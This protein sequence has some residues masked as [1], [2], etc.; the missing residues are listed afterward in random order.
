MRK[1]ISDLYQKTLHGD[2]RYEEEFVLA[3]SNLVDE[4]IARLE[5]DLAQAR[6]EGALMREWIESMRRA[7]SGELICCCHTAAERARRYCAY[8][9]AGQILSSAPLAAKWVE[10]MRAAEDLAQFV[11]DCEDVPSPALSRPE[12]G[13]AGERNG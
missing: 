4:K 5:S 7:P 3:V 1:D 6:A 8:C 10:R 12:M 11:H 9:R 2:A 13:E